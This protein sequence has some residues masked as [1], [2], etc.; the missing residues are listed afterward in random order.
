MRNIPYWLKWM[1][2]QYCTN[3]AVLL[4]ACLYQSATKANSCAKIIGVRCVTQPCSS[5]P[6]WLS[7]CLQSCNI[8]APPWML[9]HKDSLQHQLL[10]NSNTLSLFVSFSRHH[11]DDPRRVLAISADRHRRPALS[12]TP[13]ICVQSC[14]PHRRDSRGSRF[15]SFHSWPP[16]FSSL[17]WRQRVRTWCRLKLSQP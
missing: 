11:H 17:S 10:F 15:I 9:C 12:Q 13:S 6:L 4:G 1:L 5:L 2:V 14:P 3:M 16:M 7:D 8:G